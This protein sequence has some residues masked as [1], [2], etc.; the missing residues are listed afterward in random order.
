MVGEPRNLRRN[1]QRISRVVRLKRK[2]LKDTN[3]FLMFPCSFFLSKPGDFLLI[4]HSGAWWGSNSVSFRASFRACAGKPTISETTRLVA[5][6]SR[7]T[8]FVRNSRKSAPLWSRRL[9]YSGLLKSGVFG[10]FFLFQGYSPLYFEYKVE[11]VALESKV[12]N[13]WSSCG[14]AALAPTATRSRW[15]RSLDVWLD[16]I[17]QWAHKTPWDQTYEQLW[18]Y[19]AMG[20][21]ESGLKSPTVSR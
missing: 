5:S 10:F 9:E 18:T 12:S 14:E 20:L 19:G 15:P 16:M 3:D 13:E 6:P 11:A 21:V 4:P 1:I 7:C 17:E 2:Y 8:P